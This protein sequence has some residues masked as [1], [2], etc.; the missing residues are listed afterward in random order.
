MSD[1]ND[2]D[3]TCSIKC[4]CGRDICVSDYKISVCECG[5]GHKTE[6]VVRKY[7]ILFTIFNRIFWISKKIR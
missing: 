3:P 2:A 4:S 5:I 1:F 6:F 7:K